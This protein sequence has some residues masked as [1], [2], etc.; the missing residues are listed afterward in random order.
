MYQGCVWL[1][2]STVSVSRLRLAA[3]EYGSVSRRCLV[4]GEYGSVSRRCLVTGEY[5]KCC[6]CSIPDVLTCSAWTP[7]CATQ[8]LM[9]RAM[10]WY[11]TV[12]YLWVLRRFQRPFHSYIGLRQ[13]R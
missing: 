12:T 8:L 11:V 2:E 13:R 5:G 3:G 6:P 1:L 4:T 9:T 7:S 10:L